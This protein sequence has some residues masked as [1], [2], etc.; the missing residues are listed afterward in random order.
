MENKQ[1]IEITQKIENQLKELPNFDGL[2]SNLKGID[3]Y[4]AGGFIRNT[5]VGIDINDLD[6]FINAS[7]EKLTSYLSDLEN[8]GEM[9][10]GPFGAPRWF[11]TTCDFY[12]DIVPFSKF[13]V[14]QKSYFA[15]EQIL[16]DFDM[17][18]NAIAFDLNKK[19]II[20][21]LGGLQDIQDRV[22]KATHLNFPD[23]KIVSGE[24]EISSLSIFWFRLVHYKF[25]LNFDFDSETFEWVRDNKS[26]YKDL[27]KF[28]SI[29]FDPIV[30]NNYIQSLA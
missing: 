27:E 10:Y 30:D 12:A 17:T 11:S 9:V 16:S 3:A 4:V 26:R 2:C 28:K 15:I 14:N 5:L 25:L 13:V 7:L 20:D 18:I 1:V 21:P 24:I 23:I 22:I 6:L 8:N 29:F 19:Q